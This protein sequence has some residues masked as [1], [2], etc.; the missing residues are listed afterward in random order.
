MI[1][2]LPSK[3]AFFAMFLILLNICLCDFLFI[4]FSL[5]MFLIYL[6]NFLEDSHLCFLEYGVYFNEKHGC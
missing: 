4:D 6:S 5:V 3:L 2:P 1:I